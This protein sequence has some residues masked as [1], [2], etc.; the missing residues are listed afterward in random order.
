[1]RVVELRAEHLRPR[2]GSLVVVGCREPRLSWITET[3]AASWWQTAHEIEV[4]GARSGWTETDRSVLVPWPAPGLSSHECVNVRVRVRGNDGEES[5][6]SDVLRVEAALL[7]PA[8]WVAGWIGPAEDAP[9]SGPGPA[10]RLRR[11]FRL[12]RNV[13]RARLHITSA[14]VH[15]A[16]INGERVGDIVL[17]PGWSSYPHRLHYDTHDV[18]QH[19][20]VGDNV[21]GVELA[22]GWWRGELGWDSRRNCYGD[23]LGLLAQL[24][25]WFDDGSRAAIATSDDGSWRAST[26]PVVASGLY[27]GEHVDARRDTVGWDLAGFDDSAWDAAIAATPTVGRL[28]VPIAPPIRRTEELPVVEVITTPTG[29]T[30][31]DIGQNIVGRMRFVVSGDAGTEIVLRHAEVLEHGEP[32]FRPLRTAEATDRYVLRGDAI[33][34]WEPEFTFHGFRYVD[35]DGWPGTIDGSEFTAV[36]IHSDVTRIGE[37]ECDHPLLDQL[38]RNVVWSLRGNIVGLPTDCPQRD[39]RLGWTGDIQV[40]APAASFLYDVSGFLAS[41]LDDVA[42][43]QRDDGSVPV[44][45]PVLEPM[46]PRYAAG[47]SDAIVTVPSALHTA[48]AD[49]DLLARLLPS[50]R[51]WVDFVAKR[52]GPKRLW[53][54]DYQFGDWL[55]PSAPSSAPWRGA[56]A[57]EVVATACFARSAALVS[58]VAGH[59]GD[60]ETSRT[61][62]SLADDIIRAFRDEYL[63]PRGRL[64]S[65]SAAAY[66]IALQYGLVDE[67]MVDR[68][69]G[70]LERSVRA[71]FWTISTGFLG[72]PVVLHALTSAGRRRTAYRLLTQ[73]GHPSWLHPVTLGA[74]TIWERWDS[75]RSDGSVNPDG[76][77]SFN[78]Y[79]FGAV[80]DWMHE[81]IGG[82]A[83]V[84]PGWRRIRMA[85]VPG[86][87]VTSGGA[88]LHTPYGTASCRWTLRHGPDGTGVVALDAVV[89]PNTAAEVLV[90][91]SSTWRSVGSGTHHWD[92]VVDTATIEDWR[93]DEWIALT[94]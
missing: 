45:V 85:P 38:H 57:S 68:A 31:L 12:D 64:M 53:T 82:L 90:P 59:L 22:D 40:F 17:A 43:E 39:E 26:G 5:P 78:H 29:R 75:M 92:Q 24:E 93:D 23:S 74:T 62:R 14:G 80:A 55:D 88:R 56:T 20:T 32:A 35:V 70:N 6:W 65:D 50:M 33:E 72:T 49:T 54:G 1:M 30:V 79:A 48:Y 60:D 76:M 11:P 2:S 21:I 94:T 41:W 9:P 83:P 13:V 18:T 84:E 4:D 16:R 47:W 86:P 10:H 28:T 34:T 58:A 27:A 89:P 81:F 36:V 87:G 61:Y 19:L 46:Y 15:T 73:T 7:E 52:A 69:A 66:A 91:G 3:T 77:T 37:F 25:V 63:T 44:Y 67:Q 51:A 71:S 42:A 8:D